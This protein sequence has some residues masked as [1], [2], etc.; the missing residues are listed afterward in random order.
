M[1][2]LRGRGDDNA[3]RRDDP[4]GVAELQGQHAVGLSEQ[5]AHALE[6]FILDLLKIEG[7]GIG[8]EVAQG[9]EPKLGERNGG[10]WITVPGSFGLATQSDQAF[11]LGL[12]QSGIQGLRDGGQ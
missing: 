6:Q 8:I 4:L 12:T 2:V 10:G 7:F 9:L 1:A 5:T 11:D 3:R